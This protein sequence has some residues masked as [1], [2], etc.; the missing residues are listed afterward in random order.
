MQHTLHTSRSH[1]TFF[2]FSSFGMRTG[3]VNKDLRDVDL[4]G[5]S[6]VLVHQLHVAS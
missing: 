2:F 6:A 5:K 1:D 4:R 3:D